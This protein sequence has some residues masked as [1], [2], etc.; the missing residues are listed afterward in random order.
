M[1]EATTLTPTELTEIFGVNPRT[2]TQWMSEGGFSSIRTLGGPKRV[3]DDG[4][5]TLSDRCHVIVL[6]PQESLDAPSSGL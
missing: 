2:I 4:V 1:E 3:D 6:D 5:V